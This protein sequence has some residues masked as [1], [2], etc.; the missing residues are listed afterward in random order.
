MEVFVEDEFEAELDK[1]CNKIKGE[2]CIGN[3]GGIYSNRE[4][5]LFG[6]IFPGKEERATVRH[7]VKWFDSEAKKN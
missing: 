7:N 4:K 1:I 5:V 2:T 6:R 3:V